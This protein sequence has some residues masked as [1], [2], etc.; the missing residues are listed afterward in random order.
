MSAGAWERRRDEWTPEVSATAWARNLRERDALPARARD[1]YLVAEDDRDTVVAVAC[2]SAAE[3]GPAGT[4]AEVRALYV[5]PDQQ[6]RGIGRLLLQEMSAFFAAR[7]AT[8]V[9]LGVLAANHEARRF[10]EALGG[11]YAGEILFDEEGEL[12]PESVY[13]W[14][15]ITSL[16]GPPEAGPAR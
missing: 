6:K 4:V 8:S 2:G 9:R 16:L 12:L 7:G 3:A 11:R 15:D 10:Y 1:C 14:P 5:S 13:E